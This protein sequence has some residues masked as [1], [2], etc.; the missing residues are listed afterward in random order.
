MESHA[1]VRPPAPQLEAVG[2]LPGRRKGA[3]KAGLENE[4]YIK[5]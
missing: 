2:R 5:H 3:E 4:R 1:L